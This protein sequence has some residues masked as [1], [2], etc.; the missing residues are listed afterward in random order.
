MSSDASRL[1]SEVTGSAAADALQVR[2]SSM[3]CAIPEWACEPTEDGVYGA[4]PECS[5][6]MGERRV[7]D[8]PF[9]EACSMLPWLACV[10]PLGDVLLV[11]AIPLHSVSCTVVVGPLLAAV[12]PGGEVI[13]PFTFG[14]Q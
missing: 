14:S 11:D 13:A 6:Y 9:K 8:R 10:P 3:P 5:Q 7:R 4:E 1:L 2:L 12:C